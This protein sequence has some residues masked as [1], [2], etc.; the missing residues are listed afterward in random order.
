MELLG[1][2]CLL[3][4][5]SGSKNDIDKLIEIIPE[6]VREHCGKIEQND[7]ITLLTISSI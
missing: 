3:N 5:I 7:D 6:K 4:I 2:D 1:I